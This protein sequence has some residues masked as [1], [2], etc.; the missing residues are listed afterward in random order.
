MT[1]AWTLSSRT[2]PDVH[3]DL[4]FVENDPGGRAI[5]IRDAVP[6][7]ADVIVDAPFLLINPLSYPW[8]EEIRASDLPKKVG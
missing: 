2:R 5:A 1:G 6:H 4:I 8:A 3:L 7:E